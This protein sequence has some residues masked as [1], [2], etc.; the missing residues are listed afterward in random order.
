[1]KIIYLWHAVRKETMKRPRLGPS[2]T[3][4]Y[5]SRGPSRRSGGGGL[6]DCHVIHDRGTDDSWFTWGL[7]SNCMEEKFIPFKC[8]HDMLISQSLECYFASK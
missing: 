7:G 2:Q 6:R 3:K 8:G 4:V 1:M 5:S